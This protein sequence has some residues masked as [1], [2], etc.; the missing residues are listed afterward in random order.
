[1]F[2]IPSPPQN[3]SKSRNESHDANDRD[4]EL[5]FDLDL[6]SSPKSASLGTG[7]ITRKSMQA[8]GP[9]GLSD[10]PGS[11][12]TE[13][14][15]VNVKVSV[16]QLPN[17]RVLKSK[18]SS[19][20]LALMLGILA[21]ILLLGG[22]VAGLVIG[23]KSFIAAI[24]KAIAV[25]KYGEDVTQEEAAEAFSNW[26]QFA[27]NSAA[28]PLIDDPTFDDTLLVECGLVRV[29]LSSQARSE[30]VKKLELLAKPLRKIHFKATEFEVLNVTSNSQAPVAAVRLY[31]A[32]TGEL[33]YLR[34]QCRRSQ[35][36]FIRVCDVDLLDGN[37]WA[38]EQLKRHLISDPATK[39]AALDALAT[40]EGSVE[41]SI[42]DKLASLCMLPAKPVSNRIAAFKGLPLAY[43][44]HPTI[45]RIYAMACAET[46]SDERF[47]SAYAAFR[48]IHPQ[49]GS[50]AMF[51]LSYF[52]SQ[53]VFSSMESDIGLLAQTVGDD[54]FLDWYR[55]IGAAANNNQSMAV[56]ALEKVTAEAWAPE[57]AKE[58]LQFAKTPKGNVPSHSLPL[59]GTQLTSISNLF[60]KPKSQRELQRERA[61]DYDRDRNSQQ[62]ANQQQQQQQ[63]ADSRRD[64]ENYDKNNQDSDKGMAESQR[65]A[66]EDQRL[67]ENAY[68][69]SQ[70]EMS[71]QQSQ[72]L[73][74]NGFGGRQ[75]SKPTKTRNFPPP[76]K[77]R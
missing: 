59:I 57:I 11:L 38:S 60:L 52:P 12:P 45:Q 72:A 49:D 28:T 41:D 33:Q 67:A 5:D 63:L 53:Q 50:L 34:A 16:R 66:I 43:A 70:Q 39:Q 4:V 62:V 26:V 44:Q 21:S 35:D 20:A 23:A 56:Q 8:P 17:T 37:S 40:T 2:V 7:T 31:D 42:V 6:P 68:N 30:A 64:Q 24:P 3:P 18:S 10:L 1:M 9:S 13:L 48:L 77:K 76:N 25:Q 54:P 55:A 65:I 27:G 61:E 46:G 36:L 75:E 71:R 73:R 58:L 47:D 22:A 19:N 51:A 69:A 74:D 15:A 14:N 32:K 29:S